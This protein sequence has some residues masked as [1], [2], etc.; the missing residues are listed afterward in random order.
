MNKAIH[1]IRRARARLGLSAAALA[2][3]PTP[4]L[5]QAQPALADEQPQSAREDGEII[6]TARRRDERLQDV[7]IAVSV[8]SGDAVRDAGIQRFE[9]MQRAI[10]ALQVQGG[11]YGN[12]TPTFTIRSQRNGDSPI[13]VDPAV[14]V[15]FAE[16]PAVRAQGLGGAM[17]DLGSVQVLKGPQG[18]LFGRNT[19]GGAIALTPAAPTD[20]FEGYGRVTIGNYETHNVEGVVNI[21]IADWIQLR[22]GGVINRHDGFVKNILGR[23]LN[24]AKNESWRV[25]LKLEPVDGLVNSFVVN[26]W[27]AD[28]SGPA[29]RPLGSGPIATLVLPTLA[30]LYRRQRPSRCR[31]QP[32]VQH[33]QVDDHFKRHQL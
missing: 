29:S 6:V 4:L 26:G 33:V 20:K 14:S 1:S 18:T 15:Y 22:M 13:T 24:N 5:A 7:P 9:D 11:N 10:P 12:S 2:L 25:S 17:F 23:R 16:V 19:T 21:P 3:M 28:E 32:A 31:Q 27:H 30:F 8:L